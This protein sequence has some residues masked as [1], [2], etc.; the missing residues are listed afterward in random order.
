MWVKKKIP[1]EIQ[2]QCVHVKTAQEGTLARFAACW[3]ELRGLGFIDINKSGSTGVTSHA[4]HA[5]AIFL[6]FFLKQGINSSLICVHLLYGHLLSQNAI[7]SI[8]KLYKPIP[9]S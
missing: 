2:F 4:Q 6:N 8:L 9:S 3:V 1:D 5:V 7:T